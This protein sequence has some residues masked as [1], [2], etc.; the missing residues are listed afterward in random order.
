MK[1]VEGKIDQGIWLFGLGLIQEK[2]VVINRQIIALDVMVMTLEALQ[3]ILAV[4]LA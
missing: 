1:A 2:L 4:L 3:E